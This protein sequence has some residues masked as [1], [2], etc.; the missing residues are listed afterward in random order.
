MKKQC[1][2]EYG[3]RISCCKTDGMKTLGLFKGNW[4]VNAGEKA[5]VELS[6]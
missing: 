5:K 1:E 6:C 2:V 3:D 4:Q